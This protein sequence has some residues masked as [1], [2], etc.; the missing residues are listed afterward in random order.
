LFSEKLFPRLS[1]LLKA[2]LSFQATLEDLKL[3]KQLVTLFLTYV[4]ILTKQSSAY[5]FSREI[6]ESKYLQQMNSS[7]ILLSQKA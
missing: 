1:T 3:E 2:I 7:V 5:V 4:R 6:L